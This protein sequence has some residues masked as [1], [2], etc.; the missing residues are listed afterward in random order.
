MDLGI[1]RCQ[2]YELGTLR[3]VIPEP[4]QAFCHQYYEHPVLLTCVHSTLHDSPTLNSK[5]ELQWTS[6]TAAT[7]IKMSVLACQ[8][9]HSPLRSVDMLR[10]VLHP[11]LP[12][13][14]LR[15]LYN[16]AGIMDNRF[17][18]MLLP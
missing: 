6:S 3:E 17:T 13:I 7:F 15:W 16:P 5:N 2:R 9:F 14:E 12:V 1:W 10:Y 4:V 8:S 18:R 11:V